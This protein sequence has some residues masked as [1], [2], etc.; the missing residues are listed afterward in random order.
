MQHK[1]PYNIHVPEFRPEREAPV[2]PYITRKYPCQEDIALKYSHWGRLTWKIQQP[3]ASMVW[4]SVKL[5]LP[6]RMSTTDARA[7][8]LDMRVTSRLPACNIALSE[9]PMKAFRQTSL[10]LNGAIFSEDNRYRRILDACYRGTGPSSYGDNH[11][12]KP[13]VSRDTRQADEEEKTYVM[14]APNTRA[15]DSTG[16]ELYIS[17][18]YLSHRTVDSAFSLLE[19]NGPFLERARAF[20]DNL[21][22][23]GTVWEGLITSYLELG[24]FQARARKGNTAVP[25]IRDFHLRLN[26]DENLSAFDAVVGPDDRVCLGTE[27]YKFRGVPSK[28][29]E[30][31]TVPNIK[32]TGESNFNGKSFIASFATQWTEKPYLEITYT[33]YVQ[34]MAPMYNLRC[35]EY[36]YEQSNR[37]RL[38]LEVQATESPKSTQR[39]TTRVLSYPTKVYLWADY[40]DEFQGSFITG[41]TRRSCALSNIHFR[42]N[43]RPDVIF[44]PSAESCFE[45]F[46]RNTNSSLE[47]AS[48]LKSPIYCF[49]P[50][51]L[52]QQDLLAN[53]A[54]LT[55]CEW[56]AEVSLTALQ[57]QETKDQMNDQN[58]VASGY[59]NAPVQSP[60]VANADMLTAVSCEWDYLTAPRLSSDDDNYALTM[61]DVR[62][63]STQGVNIPFG[64]SNNLVAYKEFQLTSYVAGGVTK[65]P[66]VLQ[67]RCY[68][69]DN[70]AS[71]WEG[72][73]W[74][75][76][77]TAD[78][79]NGYTK[80]QVDGLFYV[81]ETFR[82]VDKQK[83]HYDAVMP[84]SALSVTGGTGAYTYT[85]DTAALKAFR[86]TL[87]DRRMKGENRKYINP[88]GS[89]VAR[90]A[91]WCPGPQA[92]L[93]DSDGIHNAA[94][95]VPD[96]ASYSPIESGLGGNGYEWI[97][98]QPN[99]YMVSGQ[100]GMLKWLADK[101][102]Q[103]VGQVAATKYG[104]RC[105][106]L[107]GD[108]ATNSHFHVA[109]QNYETQIPNTSSGLPLVSLNFQTMDNKVPYQ[110]TLKALY[111]F[112]NCQYQFTS[113]G[114]PTKVVPNLIPVGQK[115]GLP[116]LQ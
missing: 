5:V 14:I 104:H 46:Q 31:A 57:M 91:K 95:L 53:D 114:M 3:D 49:T 92:Y 89:D 111:E 13:V 8:D 28:L 108:M 83:G 60:N 34:S 70:I 82:F 105:V 99:N 56:D 50:V 103:P 37:F 25:Y 11:S 69:A 43:Q 29:F 98:I 4:T 100:G 61:K 58:L 74:A 81:P 51:D 39:V 116:Q 86:G 93:I 64:K 40:A 106:S 88:V 65:T 18:D 107:R 110:Y 32:H 42:I 67:F 45:M 41:G 85:M 20:Q 113:Q 63:E 24:P 21:D 76:V 7:N 109:M 59:K 36:Q 23:G 17:H 38:D 87:N 79:G 102:G 10:S 27:A 44:N 12:L 6:L 35:L 47:F 77:W 52:G 97:I 33:K 30:F 72:M 73:L 54:R 62:A 15:E 2:Y 26:F 90:G 78:T 9:T 75:K 112:G 1:E 55:L 101:P 19:H 22:A 66:P 16:D 84:M 115:P 80:G 94:V 48:W 68:R 96:S 71:W